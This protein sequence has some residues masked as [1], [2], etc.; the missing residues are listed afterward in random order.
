MHRHERGNAM[1]SIPITILFGLGLSMVQVFATESF[2]VK[3]GQPNAEIIIAAKPHRST[4]LAAA[5]LRTYVEK[6]SGARLP[7]ATEPSEDVPV[8]IYVGESTHAEKLGIT[9][10][11]LKYGARPLLR[12]ER[13][14]AE[15]AHVWRLHWVTWIF[16]ER[17]NAAAR[18]YM[19]ANSDLTEERLKEVFR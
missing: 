5:E 17:G 7:F 19:R 3:D 10:E 14:G 11:G 16:P 13:S 2:L 1:K 6:M 18:E 9:A 15:E 12:A 8:H 4:R